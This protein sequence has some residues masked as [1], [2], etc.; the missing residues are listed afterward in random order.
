MSTWRRR[1]IQFLP[2]YRQAIEGSDTP[3]VLW[4]ELVLRFEDAFVANDQRLL[5]RFLEY[6]AWCMSDAAGRLPS[7]SSTAVACAF[8]EHLPTHR[9][10]WPYFRSW[11]SPQQFTALIP[12]F[13]YHLSDGDMADLKKCYASAS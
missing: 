8:Y 9:E 1:A 6:A 10:Y 13:S 12:V 3:M 7:Q 2:E 4:I 11:F 5:G